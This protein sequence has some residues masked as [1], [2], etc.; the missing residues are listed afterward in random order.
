MKKVAPKSYDI[1]NKCIFSFKVNYLDKLD[2][3]FRKFMDQVTS[4]FT[5]SIHDPDRLARRNNRR[6]ASHEMQRASGQ[7]LN[8]VVMPSQNC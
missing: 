7:G 5:I 6:I 1:V 2:E 4:T 8:K 3:S